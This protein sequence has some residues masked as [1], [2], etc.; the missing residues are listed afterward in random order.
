[1]FGTILCVLSPPRG[2]ASREKYTVIS[3]TVSSSN[4]LDACA[5]EQLVE[6]TLAKVQYIP[7]VN[8]RRLKSHVDTASINPLNIFR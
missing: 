5:R 3:N 1:M 6:H 4:S 2:R 7:L 8:D